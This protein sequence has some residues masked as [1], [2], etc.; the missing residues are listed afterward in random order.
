MTVR[1][2][3]LRMSLIWCETLPSMIL[4]EPAAGGAIHTGVGSEVAYGQLFDSLHRGAAGPVALS[5]PWLTYEY[6]YFWFYYLEQIHAERLSGRDGWKQ[7]TPFRERVF[8]TAGGDWGLLAEG[9][10]YPFGIALVLTLDARMD[11]ELDDAVDWTIRARREPL[12]IRDPDG[13]T[14]ST[15]LDKLAADLLATMREKVSTSGPVQHSGSAFSVTSVIRAQGVDSRRAVAPGGTIHQALHGWANW[16]PGW[17]DEDPVDLTTGVIIETDRSRWARG[18]ALYSSDRSR[19]VWFPRLSV[20]SPGDDDARSR[21]KLRAL[22]CY[23]RNMVSV[24]V[25]VESLVHLVRDGAERIRTGRSV[26]PSHRYLLR[27][28]AGILGRLRGG[29]QTYRSRS[30]RAHIDESGILPDLN[31]LRSSLGMPQLADATEG[32]G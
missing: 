14:T 15:S 24:A 13:S 9:Y 5:L 22:Q 1:V 20:L 17:K 27:R 23:H 21:E 32:G 7:L 30:A 6:N 28:A 31:H 3:N 29:E 18:D 12:N 16:S 8:K 26:T 4:D 2:E 25:Q 10:Y 19:V 11:R